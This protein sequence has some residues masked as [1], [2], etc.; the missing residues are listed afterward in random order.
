[1]SASSCGHEYIHSFPKMA[2]FLGGSPPAWL[3]FLKEEHGS[4]K[5]L[6]RREGVSL[7]GEKLTDRHAVAAMLLDTWEVVLRV[8]NPKAAMT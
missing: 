4:Q 5:P 2:G 3:L 1:M 7:A 6:G 8:E